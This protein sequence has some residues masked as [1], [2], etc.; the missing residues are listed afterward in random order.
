MK[1]GNKKNRKG[2][3]SDPDG[4]GPNVSLHLKL[5]YSLLLFVVWKRNLVEPHN[6]EKIRDNL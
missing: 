2:K 4:A 1:K 6:Y 5:N 3:S